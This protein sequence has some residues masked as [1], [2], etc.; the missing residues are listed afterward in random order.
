MGQSLLQVAC[1]FLHGEQKLFTAG[2]ERVACEFLHGEQKLFTA[3]VRIQCGSQ[4]QV[5]LHQVTSVQL[6]R[7]THVCGYMQTVLQVGKKTF[8][9]QILMCPTSV[10]PIL[11]QP[12][13]TY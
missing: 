7:V 13:M 4:P 6:K 8:I 2:I 3:G 12:L 11:A 9:H 1:E 10:S 5:A